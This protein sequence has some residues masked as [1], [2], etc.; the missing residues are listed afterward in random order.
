MASTAQEWLPWSDDGFLTLPA[1]F[2]A[3]VHLRDGAM[4]RA[5]TRTIRQGGA[6]AVYVMPNLVP[7]I[8]TVQLALDYQKR[9][10]ELEPNVKFLMSL[11]LHE[12][13]TPEVIKDAKREGISGV[14]SYPGI[15]HRT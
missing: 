9:L 10:Q 3:H 7:P 5:V 8:T 6:D 15:E 13:I 4:M 2:D 12:S 11:Y 14:K 1:S